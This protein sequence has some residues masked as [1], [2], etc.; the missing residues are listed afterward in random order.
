MIH[1]KLEKQEQANPKRHTQKEII[2]IRIRV[3]I[4]ELKTKTQYSKSLKQKAASLKK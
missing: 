2:K 3:N 1:L 4:N